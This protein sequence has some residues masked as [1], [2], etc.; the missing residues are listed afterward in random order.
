MR[1][2]HQ[3]V[4][5]IFD[6][7]ALASMFLATTAWA[8]QS[9]TSIAEAGMPAN[10]ADYA[11]AVS[12]SEGNFNSTSPTVNGVTCYGAFQFCSAKGSVTGGTFSQYYSGTPQQ[13]ES[14]PSAQVAAWTQYEQNNWN[15]ASKNGLTSA[16]GQQVCYG[17]QCATLT[18]SSILK[19]CQFGCASNGKLANFVNSDFNCNAPGTRDG[20]GTSV[21]SYLISGSGYDVSC[22]TAQTADGGA[23]MVGGGDLATSTTTTPTG[24]IPA[25]SSSDMIVPVGTV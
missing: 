9:A 21:C 6:A 13:F 17:G 15:Q 4:R 8:G 3:S 10:C 1:R 2:L 18:Q 19:A 12:K 16:V 24:N 14:D 5:V 25:V 11:A 23:C 20:N 7:L 22:F